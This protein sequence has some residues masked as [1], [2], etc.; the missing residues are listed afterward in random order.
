[1][2]NENNIANEFNKS[3][4]WDADPTTLDWDENKNYIISRVFMFYN[5]SNYKIALGILE[6]H[7][8]KLEI[9]NAIKNS[10]EY[11]R[12]N[13]NACNEVAKDYNMEILYT[14]EK[15]EIARCK[16]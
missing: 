13:M 1:M 4:F 12:L 14:A 9:Y 2:E 3:I 7:Y 6:K 8:S 5:V 16:S 11:L 15:V 10:N